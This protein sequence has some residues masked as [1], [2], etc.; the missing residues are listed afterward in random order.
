MKMLPFA[1]HDS[2]HD[3]PRMEAAAHTVTA[4]EGVCRFVRLAFERHAQRRALAKLDNRMLDDVA[5]T[6]EAAEQEIGK[7]FWQE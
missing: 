5:I 6:R 3:T 7:R 2:D 1:K 4:I